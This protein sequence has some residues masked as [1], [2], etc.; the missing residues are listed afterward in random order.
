MADTVL[1]D[2]DRS[3]V[4]TKCGMISA[5]VRPHW[6]DRPHP[7]SLT[8]TQWSGCLSPSKMFARRGMRAG[9]DI[10]FGANAED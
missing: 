7:E 8:G 10:R 1:L 2:L 5:D 4:C 6:S 9:A 3:A